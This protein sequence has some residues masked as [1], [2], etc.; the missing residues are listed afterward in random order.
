MN[1]NERKNIKKVAIDKRIF[2]LL[3]DI[4]KFPED[5]RKKDRRIKKRRETN[6]L[7]EQE[8]R[9][10]SDRRFFDRRGINIVENINADHKKVFY[11][12]KDIMNSS[13]KFPFMKISNVKSEHNHSI[14]EWLIG[15]EDTSLKWIQE[16]SFDETRGVYVF[17]M[18]DGDF[19]YIKGYFS[20]KAYND[21]TKL[22]LSVYLDWDLPRIEFFIG[23]LL[24]EKIS[25][26]YNS[27]INEIKIQA[28]KDNI[29]FGFIIHSTELD[30]F[31]SVFEPSKKIPNKRFLE[32]VHKY[33]RPFKV[34]SITGAKSVNGKKIDGD[35]IYC[36]LT[37]EQILKMDSEFLIDYIVES[38]KIAQE[39]GAKILGLGAYTAEV[40]KKGI[41]IKDR[42]SIPIT[43]G[44]HYTIAMVLEAVFFAAE[45]INLDLSSA[46]AT[47]I[48]A[49]GTIGSICSKIIAEKVPFINLIGRN[50]NKLDNI[51]KEIL[52]KNEKVEIKKEKNYENCLSDSDIII[53][54]TNAP[55]SFI[56]V[57]N[58][59][60]GALICD[61]SLPKNI[62]EE[63]ASLRKDILIIDGG[64]I[65][66]PGKVNFNFNFGL[67]QGLCYACMAEV[68]ILAFEER[69][70][71]YS[72]GGNISL[73]KVI[74]IK[75]LGEKHGFELAQLRCFGKK[76]S[77]KQI[78]E[79]KKYH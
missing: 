66:P 43:T 78:N 58:I 69:Y 51:M 59:K 71:S 47:I 15:I 18:V 25:V 29:R 61:V 77:Q 52:N 5:R 48:G 9:I 35:L 12:L 4:N 49:T 41:L 37:S 30:L 34:S 54:A 55:F 40:G 1:N 42:L 19:K 22:F 56:D 23:H 57:K 76:I 79:I 68:M 67:P 20:I 62:S 13:R 6:K 64:I 14:T 46:K 7:I 24:K 65:K 60:R 17:E 73:K 50:T 45:K 53:I 28:E 39:L 26:I 32:A 27:I 16:N 10:T 70:E 3:K 31:F 2:N 38:G 74:E 63:N 8:K 33:S 11:L 21:K 72:L 36:M 75:K 44:T